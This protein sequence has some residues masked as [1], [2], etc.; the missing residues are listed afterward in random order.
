[1]Q[2]V[3][4]FRWKRSF[5]C[6]VRARP[7][8][9]RHSSRRPAPPMLPL[10][11]ECARQ[12]RPYVAAPKH[13]LFIAVV[14]AMSSLL[15]VRYFAGKQKYATQSK[16]AAKKTDPSEVL[17]MRLRLF[18]ANALRAFPLRRLRPGRGWAAPGGTKNYDDLY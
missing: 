11:R 4:K 1:M 15:F 5:I 13:L 8:F 14:A 6:F 18:G 17:F 7:R 2:N 3:I 16:K 9:R 12:Q 10:I